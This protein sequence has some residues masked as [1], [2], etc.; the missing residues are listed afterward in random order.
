MT[1]TARIA[2]FAPMLISENP[3]LQPYDLTGYQGLQ[4]ANFFEIDP[5]LPV[6]IK[7]Y[8]PA[9]QSAYAAAVTENL[10]SFGK[11]VG[12]DLNA[13]T[14]A[15][16]REGK[17]G[18]IVNVD[19]AGTRVEQ[20]SYCHEQQE[21]RRLCYEA[22]LVNLDEHPEWKFPFSRFHRMA[23]AYLANFNGEGGVTCPLAMTDGL[24]IALKE[25]G[26]E[27]QRERFL[28]LLTG[29]KSK[30]YFMAGQYLTERVGGSQVG[31]NRT[32]AVIQEN[33]TYR[34][35]GEKWF[36]SNPGEVWVTTARIEGTDRI[37][38]FL[39]SRLKK[40]GTVNDFRLVRKKDIIG[41]RGKLTAELYYEGTEAETMGRVSHGLANMMRYIIKV[42]RMH[43]A[44]AAMGMARRAVLE[45]IAYC[46]RRTV[47]GKPV[48]AQHTALIKLIE[49]DLRS[50]AA[51]FC[52]FRSFAL[53]DDNSP[54]Q[55]LLT[56]LMKYNITKVASQNTHEAILLLG[57]NGIL[58]DFSVLPRLHNDSI[59]NETW[60]GA[61]PVIAGHAIQAI[62]RKKARLAWDAYADDVQNRMKDQGLGSEAELVQR[63]CESCL[64][65]LDSLN[66]EQLDNQRLTLTEQLYRCFSVMELF[67]VAMESKDA[68]LLE[69]AKAYLEWQFLSEDE[70]LQ[71]PLWSST[72]AMANL[73]ESRWSLLKEQPQ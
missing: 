18:E 22:G 42:S 20:V 65:K 8:T 34:L 35:Y 46:N 49:L 40:D 61:H 66:R 58:N 67:N 50:T 5:D 60:E 52:G 69:L 29:L 25:I 63:N 7:L 37:G 73:L 17:Y 33:G 3:G 2:K 57:G 26:T 71:Q 56:P 4:D 62:L 19:Q 27:E 39:V 12:S 13:L 43:V 32:T 31:D 64:T 6:L 10:S 11:L 55:D 30:S 70:K 59:I 1:V 28:P 23:L 44:V 47:L 21:V 72:S 41:S 51:T 48:S 36:C 15:A 38:M 24:I 9:D 54:L 53:T 45:A 68:R 14:I 16:H